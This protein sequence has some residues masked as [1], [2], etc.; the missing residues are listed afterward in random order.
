MENEE[1]HIDWLVCMHGLCTGHE[2]V[3][4]TRRTT[5]VDVV[6]AGPPPKSDT[7]LKQT[8]CFSLAHYFLCQSERS[9]RHLTL[10]LLRSHQYLFALLDV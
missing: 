10:K 2:F 5:Y 7:S 9:H 3:M 8:H 1:E 6:V 4:Q